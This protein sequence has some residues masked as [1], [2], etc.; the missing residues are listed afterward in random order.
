MFICSTGQKSHYTLLLVLDLLLLDTL[1]FLMFLKDVS[2]AH[3]ASISFEKKIEII[4]MCRFD[5]WLLSVLETIVLL[6]IFLEPVLLYTGLI[7]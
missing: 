7:D 6:N 5:I 3:Q 1:L 2:Y 4:I